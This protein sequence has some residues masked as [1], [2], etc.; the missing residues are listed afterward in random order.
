MM[1]VYYA[2]ILIILLAG[3]K[4]AGLRSYNEE[5]MSL[6]ESKAVQAICA[7]LIMFHHMSQQLVNCKE[8][9]FL[10]DAGILFVAI[11][12][13][14]SGYGL[15]KSMQQKPDYV[16]H[17]LGKRLVVVL[18]P[19]YIINLIYMIFMYIGGMY[20]DL[21]GKKLAIELLLNFSGIKLV[22][23]NAW[24]IVVITIIYVLFYVFF[25]YCYEFVAFVLM[26]IVLTAY[27]G[28][29]LYLDHGSWWFQGEWWYNTV[30]LFYAGLLFARFEK[31]ILKGFKKLYY[32]L[33][34]AAVGIFIY[35]FHY[36]VK[37][38]YKYSYWCEYDPTLSRQEI[39]MHRFM[40][41]WPQILVMLVFVIGV[42]LIMLKLHFS[43]PVLNFLGKISLELYLIHGLFID[44]FHS[45]FFN[46]QKDEFYV[47]AVVLASI[48][49][50]F[51]I[52]LLVSKINPV[53]LGKKKA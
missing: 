1:Y 33:L 11:F 25:R 4:F 16:K 24:F 29:G 27:T 37:I 35:L 40:C 20:S 14:C 2:A 53:L 49:S 3:V 26:G 9:Q 6:Q 23:G 52:W 21:S 17:F 32:V 8:I 31:S 5:F 51:L 18:V 12:F 7:I 43:N 42:L 38:L 15:I 28:I 46:I 48:V 50:A 13:F 30:F 44:L 34:P 47:G 19:F 36:S 39:I 41:L 22:N 45:E 10:L